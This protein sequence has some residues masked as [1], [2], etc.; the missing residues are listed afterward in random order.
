MLPDVLEENL[1]VVFCGTAAGERSAQLQ[2]YYAGRGNKFWRILKEVDLIPELLSPHQ[3]TDLIKHRIGLTDLVK[4]ESGMDHKIDF[5]NNGAEALRGKML[6]FKPSILCFNGK[7]A[8]EEFL[9]RSVDYGIQKER[10]GSTELFV[11]PSTSGA[12]NRY[13]D[14]SYWFDLEEASRT[15]R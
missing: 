9:S 1:R 2:M 3:Y 5:K 6:R 10:I 8:A 14:T 4:H 13:W 15:P 7:R 12:A 11:A